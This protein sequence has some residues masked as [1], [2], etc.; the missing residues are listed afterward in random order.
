[1]RILWQ[2]SGSALSIQ[3]TWVQSLVQKLRS[4]MTNAAAKR[5][6]KDILHA[7]GESYE[8]GLQRST[9]RK[10]SRMAAMSV[11]VSQVASVGSDSR[12]TRGL[13]PTPLLCPWDSPGKS[14]EWVP[15]PP[16]R[17]LPDP[18]IKPESLFSPAL[19]GRF[20]V[21]FLPLA[22]PEKPNYMCKYI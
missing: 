10:A 7:G 3:G 13:Q 11:C 17:D 21:F 20:F 18:G 4:Y 15:C 5:N 12:W 1:M 8:V 16:P 22:P 2:H 14:S 9:E 19:A 6:K